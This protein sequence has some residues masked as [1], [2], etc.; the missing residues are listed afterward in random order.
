MKV[1]TS[2]VSGFRFWAATVVCVLLAATLLPLVVL[3]APPALLPPPPPPPPEIDPGPAPQPA[4]GFIELQA[5]FPPSGASR[6][7]PWTAVHWQELWTTV[8]WQDARGE[9]RAVEGWQGTLD[10]VRF[11]D[12]APT[13]QKTWWAAEDD[14]GSGPFRWMVYRARGGRLLA[15]SEAFYLPGSI[16]AT[17]TVVVSLSAP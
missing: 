9:W 12:G 17:T 3:A 11:G 7:W 1:S 2:Q 8:E 6:R 5:Q 14:L 16:G 15:T 13:G 4:G 10:G